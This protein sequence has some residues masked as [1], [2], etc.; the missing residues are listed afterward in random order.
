M[1]SSLPTRRLIPRW[2]SSAST[3]DQVEATSTA[4]KLPTRGIEENAAR[5]DEA[6]AEWRTTN[7]PGM[8]GEILSF[9]VDPRLL[10]RV[11]EIGYEAIRASAPTTPI[12][13]ALIHGLG[14]AQTDTEPFLAVVPDEGSSLHPFQQR[15]RQLRS[16]LRMAPDNPLA[17]LD[18]AQLQAAVGKN[19]A[20][21]RSLRVALSLTPSNRTVLRTLARFLVHTG[22]PDEGHRLLRRHERTPTDPWLMASEIALADAAG[23]T[24]EFLGKGKRLL[25]DKGLWHPAHSTELAGVVAMAELNSGNLKRAREAQRRALLAPNDN[26]VAQAVDFESAFGIALDTPPVTRAITAASEALLLQ[27]WSEGNPD[28][29]E[30]YAQAWHAEEPFSSRPIQMLT[31]LYAFRGQFERAASWAKAGLLTDPSDRGLLI[32]LAYTLAKWGATEQA[33]D[34]IHRLRHL[35]QKTTEPFALATEGLISYQRG[36]FEGGDRLYDAAVQLFD[37]AKQPE[38]AAYCRI[39]QALSA[40]DCQHPNLEGVLS[41][42]NSVF[43]RHPSR[44]SLMLLKTRSISGIE[45]V[46][47]ASQERRRVSQWVFDP[48][49]NTL[50]ETPGVTPVGANAIVFRRKTT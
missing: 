9:S 24:A 14:K 16:L 44:D 30:K 27:A 21:E 46:V 38:V 10:P 28:Q 32:N 19:R 34:A 48:T 12:Q 5:L 3:L 7:S 22:R 39:N 41:Q 40:L 8:L 26:V 1:K 36:D 23:A 42:A 49:T 2:R 11:V 35:H 6:I 20:A 33:E 15:I 18:F 29:V 45:P 31:A 50:T 47:A 25:Q 13:E 37:R 17:L 43:R 4:Q